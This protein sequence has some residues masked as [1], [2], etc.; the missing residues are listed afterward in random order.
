MNRHGLM[1][2]ANNTSKSLLT[3]A[4]ISIII[5]LVMLVV[6]VYSS[7]QGNYRLAWQALVSVIVVDLIYHWNKRRL[8]RR[9]MRLFMESAEVEKVG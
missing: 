4:L 6:S 1:E 9:Y 7:F 3:S 8:R 5:Q 2:E